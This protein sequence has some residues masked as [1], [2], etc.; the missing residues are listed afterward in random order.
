MKDSQI[1]GQGFSLVAEDGDN[2][3]F[4]AN[5]PFT[6]AYHVIRVLDHIP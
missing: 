2:V 5:R 6:S 1:I 3:I 4:V